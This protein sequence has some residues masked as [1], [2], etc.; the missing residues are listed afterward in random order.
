MIGLIFPRLHFLGIIWGFIMLFDL[1]TSIVAYALAFHYSFLA[2]VW[3]FVVGTLW[4]YLLSR[5]AGFVFDVFK[6]L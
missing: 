2:G 4:W 5:G 1:P 3:I 6:H